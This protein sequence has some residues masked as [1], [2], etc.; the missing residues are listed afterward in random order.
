[1]RNLSIFAIGVIL[2]LSSCNNEPNSLISTEIQGSYQRSFLA[3][4]Q[5]PLV[6]T[7]Q[8]LSPSLEGTVSSIDQTPT[9]II[10]SKYTYIGNDL[11]VVT[12]NQEELLTIPSIWKAYKINYLNIPE[13]GVVN[14][15]S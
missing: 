15:D 4:S 14:Y 8:S 7:T 6:S 5:L 11:A 2:S 13:P 1:M 12:P 3:K 10:E 9:I